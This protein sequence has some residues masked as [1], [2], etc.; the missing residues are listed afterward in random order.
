MQFLYIPMYVK[1]LA[2]SA[3][4]ASMVFV[5]SYTSITMLRNILKQISEILSK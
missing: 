2:G 1:L 3:W 5:G 4:V